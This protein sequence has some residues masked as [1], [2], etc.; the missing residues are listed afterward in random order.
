MRKFLFALAFVLLASLFFAM[1]AKAQE[2]CDPC[3][4]TQT[5]T[6]EPNCNY[7]K[8]AF[9]TL[10]NAYEDYYLDLVLVTTGGS[11]YGNTGMEFRVPLDW[12]VTDV[13]LVQDYRFDYMVKFSNDRLFDP[14]STFP[15]KTVNLKIVAQEKLPEE[16]DEAAVSE[17]DVE[18]AEPNAEVH[19]SIT[20]DNGAAITGSTVFNGS[21]FTGTMLVNYGTLYYNEDPLD[22]GGGYYEDVPQITVEVE[23]PVT[24]T[25]QISSTSIVT[26]TNFVTDDDTTINTE[27]QN[28]PQR[29]TPKNHRKYESRQANPD[30][31]PGWWIESREWL[32]GGLALRDLENVAM[33]IV[34][35]YAVT[36]VLLV[37]SMLRR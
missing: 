7:Y 25:N 3:C 30:S 11:L 5:P 22:Y 37:V 15:C 1:P 4:P 18:V 2:S 29:L 35:V 8:V 32:F 33:G 19:D 16:I 26:S 13:L 6:T 24:V 28:P 31:F 34:V 27:P 9:T 12:T 21:A 20:L 23:V 10:V 36:L 14:F 17:S